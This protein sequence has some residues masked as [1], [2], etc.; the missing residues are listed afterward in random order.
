M[1]YDLYVL[2][3]DR[4]ESQSPSQRLVDSTRSR[5]MPLRFQLGSGQ[6]VQGLEI[7][8][9][10]LPAEGD[11]EKKAVVFA[12]ATVPAL[13]GYGAVGCPPSI[14]P[15]ATLLFSNVELVKVERRRK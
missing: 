15:N 9:A 3:G 11:D 12:E 1:H 4:E 7:A 2:E 14:P 8:V 10:C 13:Y 5:E 6:V